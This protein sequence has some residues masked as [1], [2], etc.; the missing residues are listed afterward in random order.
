MDEFTLMIINLLIILNANLIFRL[1]QA[2]TYILIIFLK[3]NH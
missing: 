1:F 3:L 2:I